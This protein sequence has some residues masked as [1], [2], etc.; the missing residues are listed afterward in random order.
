M[1]LWSDF[2]GA[3]QRKAIKNANAQA[4]NALAQGYSGANSYYDQAAS[5]YS[6]FVQGGQRGQTAYENSLGL[7]GQAGAQSA[8]DAYASNPAYQAANNYG[9]DSLAKKYNANGRM[10]SGSNQLAMARAGVENYGNYQ[11]QLA[12]LGQQGLQATGAQSAVRAGQGDMAMGYGAT[13]A[14]QATGYGNALAQASSTGIN[15]LLG[16]GGMLINGYSAWNN[17]GA[18][19]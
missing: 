5:A 3:S 19:R 6:P 18:K 15:N 17:P 16:L 1:S 12:G 8:Y 13:R 7:N 2:T 10:D 9:M 14:N 4:T 11:N